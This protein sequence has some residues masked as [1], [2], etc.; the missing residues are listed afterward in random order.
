MRGTYV[1]RVCAGL[2]GSAVGL[3][4]VLGPAGSGAESVEAPAAA[5]AAP[6]TQPP[7]QIAFL[8]HM[9]QP[10]YFPYE[11]APQTAQRGAYSFDLFRV[12]GDRSG[13]Y[14]SWPI[15]AVQSALST[16]HGGAQVSFSGSLIENLDAFESAGWG[17]HGWKSRWRESNH[18]KTAKGNPRLDLV[19]FGYHHPLLPLLDDEAARRQ[20]GMHKGTYAAA[21]NAPGVPNR[22]Y[23]KGFF[24]PENAFA[25]WMIPALRAEGVEWA[26]VDNIHFQRAC[27]AYPWTSNGGL[28]PPNRADQRNPNPGDWTQLRDLWA[29]T[30][31]SAGWSFR[32][33]YVRYVDPA[34]GQESK[35]VAVPTARYMG[36]EDGRGGFGALQYDKVMSQ[37]ASANTDP[38]HP[39]LI[40]LHH[41]GDNYGGG[42][43][44]YYHANWQRMLSWLSQNGQRFEL[45]TI[46]DYLDRFPV[47]SDDVIHVEPGSWSGADNGDAEFKKW[48]GDANATTGYSP[49]VNSWA[50]MVAATNRVKTAGSLAPQSNEQASAWRYLLNGFA[51]DYWYWDGTEIWDSNPTRAANLAT[52]QA[53]KLLG[54]VSAEQVPPQVFLPQRE[55]YNPGAYEFGRQPKPAA[56]KVWTLAYDTA[57][58][59]RVTLRYRIDADG[60][61]SPSD[62]HNETYAGGA[63]VGAWRDLAM[64]VD[65]L[66]ASQTRPAP[67]HQAPRYSA[68]V[69]AHPGSL[70]DYY[71]EAEDNLGNVQRSPILSVYV[72][73]AGAP[74]S[75]SPAAP[76]ADE[77]VTI[78]T[79][80]PGV[81]RWGVDGW[82]APPSGARPAGSATVAGVVETRLQGP[83]AQGRYSATLGPFLGASVQALD[84]VVRNDDGTWENRGGLDY[85]VAIAPMPT[86]ITPAR[87][88]WNQRVRI[89]SSQPGAV[90]WGIDGWKSPPAWLRPAGSVDAGG[91]AETPLQPTPQGTYALE[92][93]P[94]AGPAYVERI[95]FA[96]RLNS[97]AWDTQGGRDYK[98]EVQPREL[99]WTPLR[100]GQ[101]QVFSRAGGTLRF[102]VDGWQGAKDLPLRGPDASGLYLGAI[103]APGASVVDFALRRP[104]GT[105]DNNGGQDYH[106]R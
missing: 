71:V 94:F 63:G 31:V 87:P 48:L 11:S 28:V 91:V 29:P 39:L 16:P 66:P 92:L 34:S 43:D 30:K 79:R 38:A 18:W 93:G 54:G 3:V 4:C 27:E 96:I 81:V 17:F 105:W 7:I 83:D 98:V 61:N 62:D 78:T 84:F 55:P 45:T 74:V 99:W 21:W 56:F 97:G 86:R 57:G 14:A 68:T 46:Q 36:N 95:E 6:P 88:A 76:A 53:D 82:Q 1:R 75:V 20:I 8:W 69:P 89:E 65:A 103:N 35:I 50:S 101:V 22:P 77:R 90:R 37:I 72:G 32:P 60:K 80:K 33:H 59:R 13:P 85:R 47:A 26:L 19:G 106:V 58:L 25:S 24:P 100:N 73:S 5:V 15:D 9:P 44:S 49:D 70:L 102:G 40:V 10:I 51:S 2:I 67:R 64:Q 104:D 23:S 41:D 42:A 52:E 12:H